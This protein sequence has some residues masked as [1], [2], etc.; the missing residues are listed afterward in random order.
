MYQV[1]IQ[2][3]QWTLYSYK[4][5]HL[6]IDKLQIASKDYLLAFVSADYFGEW[7]IDKNKVSSTRTCMPL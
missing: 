4:Q 7:E 5:E 3:K 2:I 1:A 6:A